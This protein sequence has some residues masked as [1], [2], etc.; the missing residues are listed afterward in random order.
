M[1]ALFKLLRNFL[2]DIFEKHLLTKLQAIYVSVTTL[3]E[4]MCLTK[5]EL[6]FSFKSGLCCVK[7][8]SDIRI[9]IP[10]LMLM[11]RC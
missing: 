3:L 5:I 8:Y 7:D 6:I 11:P 10:M 2:P 1:V 9:P 4:I